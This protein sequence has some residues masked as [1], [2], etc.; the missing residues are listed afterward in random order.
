M[1]VSDATKFTAQYDLQYNCIEKNEKPQPV[2]S[3]N[4]IQK[5][6]YDVNGNLLKPGFVFDDFNQLV[7][8]QGETIVYDALGRR[9]QKGKISYLY[10]DQEEIG[11]FEANKQKELKI[12]GYQNIIAIEIKNYPYPPVQDVQGT[13]RLVRQY[14][15]KSKHLDKLDNEIVKEIENWLNNRPR[16]VL[17]FRTPIEVFHQSRMQSISVALRS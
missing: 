3:I 6:D 11:S 9:L 14:L 12:P 2:D 1:L 8:A 17:Q 4:Q 5:L 16:K 10:I 7:Q 15:P 13:I